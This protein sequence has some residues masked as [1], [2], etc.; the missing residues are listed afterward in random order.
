MSNVYK[1]VLINE[2]IRILKRSIKRKLLKSQRDESYI[3]YII[4]QIVNHY[5]NCNY[6]NENLIRIHNQYESI[7]EIREDWCIDYDKTHCFNV[8]INGLICRCC[9]INRTFNAMEISESPEYESEPMDV[10]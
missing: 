1:K 10:D 7:Y 6:C 2:L 5:P 4:S 9:N 3:K 8:K